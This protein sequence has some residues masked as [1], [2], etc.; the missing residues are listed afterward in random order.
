VSL[1]AVATIVSLGR[2]AFGA[3]FVAA[4]EPMGSRWIGKPARD[5]RV[6]ILLRAVGARDIA[7][8]IGTARA[9]ARGED[10]TGWLVASAGCDAIDLAA[11]LAA[12]DE[13]PDATVNATLVLA[14]GSGALFAAA[15]IL[16][17]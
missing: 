7:I 1:R 14:A 12:R 16:A 5:E 13:L 6:G 17:D 11:T 4:A 3:A 2:A 8:G 10:A 15:A 9:L